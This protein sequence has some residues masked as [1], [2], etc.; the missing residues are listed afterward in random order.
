M[1]TSA[2]I[3]AITTTCHCLDCITCWIF[4]VLAF[5]VCMT[6]LLHDPFFGQ[7]A[8]PETIRQWA[9]LY[10][11]HVEKRVSPGHLFIFR[12]YSLWLIDRVRDGFIVATL[13]WPIPSSSCFARCWNL[14]VNHDIRTW[15]GKR[16]GDQPWPNTVWRKPEAI[17]SRSFQQGCTTSTRA[18]ASSDISGRMFLSNNIRISGRWSIGVVDSPL[19]RA[20]FTGSYLLSSRPIGWLHDQISWAT[21]ERI[22]LP[23]C[24]KDGT[25]W[26][27]GIDINIQV[28]L[29]QL[30]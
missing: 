3:G 17:D 26:T 20:A 8:G 2:S 7:S 15:K 14:C 24:S 21:C 5:T 22:L 30:S 1:T 4:F 10:L 11:N 29:P 18:F 12:G 6:P 16:E 13:P 25:S 28:V 19:P 27:L 9:E 23:D